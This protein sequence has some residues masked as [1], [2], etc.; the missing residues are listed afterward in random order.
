G[1]K[2]GICDL[3]LPYPYKEYAGL[4]IE[5]KYGK[6]KLSEYQEQFIDFAARSGYK[7]AVCYTADEA[8]KTIEEYL[9]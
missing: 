7:T 4:Y 9:M 6:N 5:M 3:F 1:V 2:A 8:I